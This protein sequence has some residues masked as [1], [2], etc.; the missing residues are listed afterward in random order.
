MPVEVLTPKQKLYGVIPRRHIGLDSIR[1]VQGP[2]QQG[3]RDNPSVDRDTR[4]REGRAGYDVERGGAVLIRRAAVGGV[5]IVDQTLIKR[6][7]VHLSLPV[8]DNHVAEA[9]DFRLL[10]RDTS[11]QP[12]HL[13]R[14]QGF[15]RGTGNQGAHRLVETLRGEETVGIC[16]FGDIRIGVE[17]RRVTHAFV[18]DGGGFRAE[19]DN[20]C[21]KN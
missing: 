8:I 14:H 10:V 6:P 19:D 5:D 9:I 20:A 2:F 13:R 16:R 15:G 12:G 7:G 1:F 4:K 18:R 21:G 11:R 17:H 3:W